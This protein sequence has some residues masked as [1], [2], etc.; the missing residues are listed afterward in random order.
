MICLH[1]PGLRIGSGP[2]PAKLAGIPA[3]NSWHDHCL[4]SI[5]MNVGLFSAASAMNVNQRWLE[6]TSEN[7]AS[8]TVPGF[9]REETRFQALNAGP[10][11]PPGAGA[12][13]AGASGSYNYPM[14]AGATNFTQGAFRRTEVPT[15]M[16]I[17][18]RGFFAVEIPGVGEAY[19]RDGEFH[20]DAGGQLV[21]KEG[22]P[23][24]GDGGPIL[25]DPMNQENLTVLPDGTLRQGQQVL[26]QLRVVE[27]E[28]MDSL[29]PVSGG[30]FKALPNSPGPVDSEESRVRQGFLEASNVTVVREMADM[31]L[32]LRGYEAS[33]KLIHSQDERL[34]KTIQ[35]LGDGA[36]S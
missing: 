6:A 20:V 32:A 34:G 3:D 16:A 27:F 1:D 18:G 14:V 12:L 4:G 23:V 9:K 17:E 8:Q 21:T 31:I 29:Q 36:A 28:S 13:A 25:V 11:M 35:T 19:T 5:V 2:K 24:L 15:D 30:L 22:H 7:L 10:V 26:G 33:Q